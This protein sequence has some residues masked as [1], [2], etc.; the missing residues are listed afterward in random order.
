QKKTAAGSLFSGLMGNCRAGGIS[1][2]ISASC[3]HAPGR[4]RSPAPHPVP[5]SKLAPVQIPPG[6]FS[7]I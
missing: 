7:S 1:L 5:L 2:R 4:L 6:D 3:L